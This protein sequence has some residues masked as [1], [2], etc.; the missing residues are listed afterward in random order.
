MAKAKKS[1]NIQLTEKIKYS[2]G[3]KFHDA[4]INVP[5]NFYSLQKIGNVGR[6]C[7]F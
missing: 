3:W 7:K 6:V 2:N 1:P 4:K 5:I